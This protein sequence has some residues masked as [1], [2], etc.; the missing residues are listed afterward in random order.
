MR[1]RLGTRIA[2]G[3]HATFRRALLAKCALNLCDVRRQVVLLAGET[4]LELG[5]A[6]FL[7]PDR[8]LAEL[9]LGLEPACQGL[10]LGLSPLGLPQG[11]PTGDPDHD[12]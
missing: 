3:R 12:R 1:P 11:S 5:E 2:P 7:E 8:V 4:L 10:R 9:E 6:P